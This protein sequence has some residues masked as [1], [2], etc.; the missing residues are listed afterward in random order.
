MREG[1]RYAQCHG[2]QEVLEKHYMS[3]ELKT[4]MG[5]AAEVGY[6]QEITGISYEHESRETAYGRH[7]SQE[8]RLRKVRE[9][10]QYEKINANVLIA[11]KTSKDAEIDPRSVWKRVGTHEY[12]ALAADNICLLTAPTSFAAPCQN[13]RS[14]CN[15]P[16]TAMLTIL[17][18]EG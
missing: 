11:L 3:P 5:L 8:E 15:H 10:K 17:T 4:S 6:I 12:L 14:R 18:L 7:E 2:T 1:S 16:H 9:D 13:S